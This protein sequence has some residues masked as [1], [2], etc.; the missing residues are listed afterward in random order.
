MLTLTAIYA[1]TLLLTAVVFGVW[2]DRLGRRKIFVICSGLVA[3]CASLLLGLGQSW[4]TAV[5]AAV[6][7]GCSFG[8]YTSVDFALITEVL[9]GAEDRGKD[10]GVINIANALPQVLAPVSP[11]CSWRWSRRPVVRSTRTA[12]GSRPATWSCTP[13]RSSPACSGRSS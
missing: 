10:L 5:V 12:T 6:V 1:G 9:P 3:A 13:S 2:S 8:I 4:P 7:M 11:A